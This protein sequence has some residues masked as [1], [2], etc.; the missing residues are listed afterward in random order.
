MPRKTDSVYEIG[1]VRLRKR[2]NRWQAL[3]TTPEGRQR[4]SLK[5]PYLEIAKTKAREIDEA[6]SRGDYE[7]IASHSRSHGMT[8]SDL[9]DEFRT[10]YKGWAPSTWASTGPTINVLVEA[11]GDTSLAKL[12]TRAIEGYLARKQDEG[13]SVAS[14]NRCRSCLSTIFGSGIRWG[15]LPRNP[16]E[17]I[18]MLREQEK[19][20]KP[21][22]EE[23]LGRLLGKLHGTSKDVASIAVDTGMRKGELRRLRWNDVDFDKSMIRVQHTKNKTPREIPMTHRVREIL[24]RHRT[25]NAAGKVASLSVFGNAADILKAVRM[26]G[27]EA[28]I[29]SATVHRLRDT[30]C[31][32][33][34]DRGVQVDRIRALAGHS[35]IRMTLR[36]TE[37][38][39]AG[40]REAIAALDA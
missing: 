24:E 33:L 8:F 19:L 10:N 36:Y 20:P 26:A 25:E 34:A 13:W 5:T 12:S 22:S 3:Y 21:Y 16:V 31:T 7:S 39:E 1:Q 29:S 2:E 14:Y 28:G 6:L 15:Y 30:F 9:C 17:P 37:T 40:L 11:F 35:D 32:R 38:R 27:E 4:K 18:S 23:E